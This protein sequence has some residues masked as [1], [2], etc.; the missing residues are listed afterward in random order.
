M[1][2]E[3]LEA[4][5]DDEVS[6]LRQIGREAEADRRADLWQREINRA[7]GEAAALRQSPTPTR[8]R[9]TTRT[10]V[11]ATAVQQRSP[12]STPI[13]LAGRAFTTAFRRAPLLATVALLLVTWMVWEVLHALTPLMG[14]VDL[15]GWA[16]VLVAVGT[17]VVQGWRAR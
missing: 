2:V 8:L 1:A 5:A 4:L 10:S 16:T 7:L 6:H 14:L 17:G 9:A 15:V 13:A 12:M 3:Q 11:G